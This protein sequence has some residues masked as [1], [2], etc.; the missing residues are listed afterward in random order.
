MI[1][2]ALPEKKIFGGTTAPCRYGGAR[3]LTTLAAALLLDWAKPGKRQSDSK[4]P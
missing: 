2:K 4:E 3:L 1:R